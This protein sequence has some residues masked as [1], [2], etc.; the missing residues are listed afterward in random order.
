MKRYNR[1]ANAFLALA[2]IDVAL[3]ASIIIVGLMGCD[4]IANATQCAGW[5]ITLTACAVISKILV[6]VWLIA[7]VTAAKR[8]EE[9]WTTRQERR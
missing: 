7:P 1:T 6:G 3:W 9:S 8:R 2:A 4:G 5:W